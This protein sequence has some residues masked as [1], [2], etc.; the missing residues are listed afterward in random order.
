MKNSQ[1]YIAPTV[2][3]AII[4]LVA[5]LKIVAYSVPITLQTLVIFTAAAVLTWRQTALVLGAYLLL[6]GLGLTVFADYSAGFEKLV[7]PT[8]GFLWGFWGVGILLSLQMATTPQNYFLPMVAFF[9]AHLGLLIPGLI[10]VYL[11]VEGA[12]LWPTFVRLIPG[13]LI[14]SALGGILATAINKK[15]PPKEAGA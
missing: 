14:K 15:L 6:G 4:C 2:A 3:L 10:V 5:P 7:G 12:E 8:A 9:V 1:K 13:L 11:K